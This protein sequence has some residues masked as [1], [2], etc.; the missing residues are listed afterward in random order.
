MIQFLAELLASPEYTVL[1]SR[2]RYVQHVGDRAIRKA[3]GGPKQQSLPVAWVEPSQ[4]R[5]NR[6]LQLSQRCPLERRRTG[7]HK[8]PLPVRLLRADARADFSA[9]MPIMPAARIVRFVDRYPVNPGFQGAL[10]RPPT[11]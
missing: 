4:S 3:A 1:G 11:A 2:H 6:R 10:I 8:G 7:V 9:A 5:N